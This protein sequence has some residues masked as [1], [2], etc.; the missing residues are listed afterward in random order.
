MALRRTGLPHMCCCC[1]QRHKVPRLSEVCAL[2]QDQ[3][4][5]FG[6]FR[7]CISLAG[8]SGTK[9]V[10]DPAV[11][12]Q[13]REKKQLALSWGVTHSLEKFCKGRR[14]SAASHRAS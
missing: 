6:H 7:V 5:E 2:Q 12:P 9:S 8:G 4:A 11:S 3:R 14:G 13:D 1:D 10:P